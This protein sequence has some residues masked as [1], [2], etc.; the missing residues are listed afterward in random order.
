M[1]SS[2]VQA[3]TNFYESIKKRDMPG[4]AAIFADDVVW[5]ASHIPPVEGTYTGKQAVLGQALGRIVANWGGIYVQPDRIIDAGDQVVVLG[6]YRDAAAGPGETIEARTVHAWTFKDGKA[7]R[8]EQLTDTEKFAHAFALSPAGRYPVSGRTVNVNGLEIF[9][10]EAG[11]R[12]APALVLLHGF[13]SSSHMFR[14]LIPELA[15]RYRVLALDYPGFGL[16]A[17]PSP[18]EFAYT[19]DNLAKVT[20]NWLDAVGVTDFALYMQDYGGP[21]GFR[22]ASA[23]PDRVRGIITQNANAYAEGLSPNLAP[24]VAYMSNPTP[25][26]EAP[27]RQFLTLQTTKFQY[28]HGARHPERV[29]PASWL[30]DQF[31]LDRPGNAEIQLSLIRDYKTNPGLYPAWQKYL[32]DR[33]PPTLVVWGKNDPFFTPE[34]ANAFTRDVPGAE[35]HLLDTG[36]FALEEDAPR[37]GQLIRRFRDRI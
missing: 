26:T 25:E 20:T 11:E 5:V 22:I 17:S 14:N 28:T 15:G 2:N 24:L 12:T 23:Q 1:A 16:S 9:Y 21:V 37:I 19:F 8:V 31:F 36:H 29:D 35:V 10:R 32:R 34:G 7:V 13:P 33:R 6:R 18:Q 30:V 3:V 27:V 4:V